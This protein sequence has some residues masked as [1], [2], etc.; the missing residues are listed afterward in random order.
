MTPAQSALLQ[1]MLGQENFNFLVHAAPD[2]PSEF[3]AAL[4][5]VIDERVKRGI[6]Q[7]EFFE[8]DRLDTGKN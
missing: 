5:R 4:N 2:R 6:E 1:S 7:H 8:H 3:F